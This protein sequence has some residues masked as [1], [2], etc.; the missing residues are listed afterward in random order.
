MRSIL[1]CGRS[2]RQ[3]RII[4]PEPPLRLIANGHRP[5]PIC[6]DVTIMCERSFH[7]TNSDAVANLSTADERHMSVRR[8]GERRP[9]SSHQYWLRDS[10]LPLEFYPMLFSV[11]S[12][13]CLDHMLASASHKL[14][15]TQ[16][17]LPFEAAC[18]TLTLQHHM[19]FPH[20]TISIY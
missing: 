5:G 19:L 15:L 6:Q 3:H 4:L 14:S 17:L 9:H 1:R 20:L 10:R 18:V 16:S 2:R 13:E 7:K 12:Q 11:Q 8:R